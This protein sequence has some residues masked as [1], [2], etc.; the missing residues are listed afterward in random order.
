MLD[1]DKDKSRKENNSMSHSMA[2]HKHDSFLPNKLSKKV[3]KDLNT[4]FREMHSD[5]KAFKASE[6]R[7][8]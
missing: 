8:K 6:E 3:L 4:S 2:L 1:D 5:N 7:M